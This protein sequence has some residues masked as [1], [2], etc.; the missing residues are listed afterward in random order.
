[1]TDIN[2]KKEQEI[3]VNVDESTKVFVESRCLA[4]FN[5]LADAINE[6]DEQIGMMER[7][8]HNALLMINNAMTA[9]ISKQEV[10]EDIIVEKLGVSK[11]QIVEKTID[12]VKAKLK[13]QQAIMQKALDEKAKAESTEQV[14]EE[15][16]PEV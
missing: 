6:R 15:K 12:L 11:E 4:V 8:V 2:E 7:D 14:Q 9:L 10:L 3:E 13:E 16:Q 5:R 1:M